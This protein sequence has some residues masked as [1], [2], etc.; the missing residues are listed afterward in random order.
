MSATQLVKRSAEARLSQVRYRDNGN[1]DISLSQPALSM[2]R[3]RPSTGIRTL[4]EPVSD[5]S[6][7]VDTTE[8]LGSQVQVS[9]KDND[10]VENSREDVQVLYRPVSWSEMKGMERVDKVLERLHLKITTWK[11]NIFDV[12]R[13]K[14]GKE[15]TS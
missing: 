10:L 13:G 9:Q 15:F 2:S 1:E 6:S 5:D 12:S 11:K 8:N 3:R 7:E 14:V 4:N